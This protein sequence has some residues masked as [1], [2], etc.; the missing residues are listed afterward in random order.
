VTL[1]LGQTKISDG[2][3]ETLA[4]MP[5]LRTVSVFETKITPKGLRSLARSTKK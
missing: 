2:S 4:S 3:I 1:N 5:W